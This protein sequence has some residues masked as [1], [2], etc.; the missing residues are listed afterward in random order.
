MNTNNR[1]P[2]VHSS[3]TL[4][5][6]VASLNCNSLYKPSKPEIRRDMIRFLR[7][8]YYDTIVVQGTHT[9]TDRS[10]TLLD[11]QFQSKSSHGPLDVE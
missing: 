1:N 7:E 11:Q 2:N 4:N 5:L 6:R 3:S 9:T 10:I 8:N